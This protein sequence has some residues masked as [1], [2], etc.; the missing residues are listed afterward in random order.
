MDITRRDFLKFIAAIPPAAGLNI[1]L[2]SFAKKGKLETFLQTWKNP[3]R[4]FSQA[5]FWFWNDDLSE[6]EIS[7]QLQDFTDHGIYGFVIH[8][9]VGLPKSIDWLNDK[10]IYYMKYAIKEAEKKNMWCILYDEGMY[11]SGSASGQVVAENPLFRPRGL[12]AIDLDEVKPGD[13]KYGFKINESGKPIIKENQNL[14]T[15][16]KRKT[17]GHK[18]A[19]VD[20]YISPNYSIIRGLHFLE[21]NPARRADKKEVAEETPPVADILNPEAV[22]SFIKHSYQKYYDELGNYFGKTVKAIFTDEPS[23][24][25]R[26]PERGVAA[27][28]KELLGFVNNW[29][30]EDFTDKLPSLWFDDEPDSKVNREVYNRAL[31]ARLEETYYRQL[32]DWCIAHNTSLVGHPGLPED[33]GHLRYFQIPGQDVV[34]RYIL[35]DNTNA[36]EGTES[37]TAKCASSAMIHLKRRR[38]SNE[39]CGAYG[40]E[41][42]FN[43][44]KWLANWLLIRG[45]NLLIPHAFYYSVRGPRVD[46][47]PPDVGPNNI[48]WNEFKPFADETRRL[49]WLNTD[50][51]HVCDIAILSLNDY[52]LWRSAKILFQNQYDFNYLEARHLWEDAVVDAQGIKLAGMHYKALIVEFDPPKEAQNAIQKLESSGRIIRMKEN[53][54]DNVLLNS[55][56][57]IIEKDID[58]TPL[59]KDIRIR[60][61]VKN[62]YHFYM[63]FN[64]GEEKLECKPEFKIK[65]KKFL[66]DNNTATSKK[67]DNNFSLRLQPHDLKVI[68]VE[69]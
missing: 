12:F 7:R 66:F 47:R 11:P 68:M 55:V 16:V 37:T 48:W 51:K 58:I 65:G 32:S 1:N 42:T 44:M 35:P 5:P 33:I 18:I 3:P 53:D 19:I 22:K 31:N 59:T 62:N 23:F 9:R 54:N 64:E 14:I 45:C 15:I 39:Y 4:E 69:S 34:W 52:L 36:L 41:F 10:M 67:L 20:R 24:L 27:G 21:E 13:E 17:N 29:L 50:S 40:H 60:H 63:L 61:V 2:I 49:C 46:E 8:P 57:G 43:E 28:N 56:K 26:K 6:K 38:N 30:K 25:G